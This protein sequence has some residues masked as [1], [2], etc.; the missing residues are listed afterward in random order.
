MKKL[1]SFALFL[2]LFLLI[3]PSVHAESD[4]TRPGGGYVSADQAVRAKMVT[5]SKL[6]E[7]M[8][9]PGMGYVSLDPV[10]R[11]KMIAMS[12]AAE[13][14]TQPKAQPVAQQPTVQAQPE[15]VSPAVVVPA[16]V[17]ENPDKFESVK[18]YTDKLP[19]EAQK[20]TTSDPDEFGKFLKIFVQLQKSHSPDL[21]IHTFCSENGVLLQ[22]SFASVGNKEVIQ[23]NFEKAYLRKMV[24][25]YFSYE[26]N[27]NI[28]RTQK[29][30]CTVD[31]LERDDV[32]GKSEG[33]RFGAE[34]PEVKHSVVDSK[35]LGWNY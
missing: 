6:A 31:L 15:A 23:V 5:M 27:R 28:P 12:R 3:A 17:E 35:E 32:N 11:A 26:I 29:V 2:A 1:Q 9:T 7:E 16:V 8:V 34:G 18:F 33:Y 20:L 13:M 19:I 24:D 25:N 14:T 4:L 10:V 21:V 22:E 30:V